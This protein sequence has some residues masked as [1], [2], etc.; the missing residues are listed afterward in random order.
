MSAAHR[1]PTQTQPSQERSWS[2]QA[3]QAPAEQSSPGR[4]ST[5]DLAERVS[6]LEAELAGL[7][8]QLGI[9]DD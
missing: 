2:Q 7:K 5:S 3:S 6:R 8:E 1:S 9:E 4:A